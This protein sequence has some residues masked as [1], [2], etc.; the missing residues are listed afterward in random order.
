MV[1]VEFGWGLI[2]LTLA[3]ATLTRRWLLPDSLA[4]GPWR[5]IRYCTAVT[6]TLAAP[7]GVIWLLAD[8]AV[9]VATAGIVGVCAIASVDAVVSLGL[10]R[11]RQR[12]RWRAVAADRGWQYRRRDR[13]PPLAEEWKGDPIALAA[14]GYHFAPVIEGT[15]AGI[16]FTL[17]GLTWSDGID[18]V[19]NIYDTVVLVVALGVNPGFSL[20]VR[21][22]RFLRMRCAE[23]EQPLALG[24]PLAA[25]YEAFTS[26]A[27]ALR[28]CLMP[29]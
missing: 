29:S 2:I 18:Q 4:A 3:A 26:D 25:T 22:H 14:D 17:S 20:G 15:L 21:P 16:Q 24:D 8:G 23:G 27:S 13:K 12:R 11:S 6:L 5:R 7:V 28:A 10:Q 1:L 19:K 9:A